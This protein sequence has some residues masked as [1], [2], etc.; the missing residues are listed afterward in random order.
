MYKHAVLGILVIAG[1]IPDTSNS[2]ARASRRYRD[3]TTGLESTFRGRFVETRVC[4]QQ[5][6]IID[7][8]RAFL[9]PQMV[10]SHRR[11]ESTWQATLTVARYV[12]GQ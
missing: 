1:A 6:T 9:L 8:I 5:N 3:G 7:L 4:P 2:L 11:K 10:Y 12:V